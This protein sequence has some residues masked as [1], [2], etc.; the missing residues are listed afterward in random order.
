MNAENTPNPVLKTLK[1][2]TALSVMTIALM[3]G[4]GCAATNSTM[5][6]SSPERWNPAQLDDPSRILMADDL[7]PVDGGSTFA[8]LALRHAETQGDWL[9]AYPHAKAAFEAAPENDSLRR[10]VFLFAVASGDME[11]ASD[12]SDQM[13][14]NDN[15]NELAIT[16]RLVHAVDQGKLSEA[17]EILSEVD[18][19]SGQVAKFILPLLRAWLEFEVSEDKTEALGMIQALVEE[20]R[21]EE[22]G[23]DALF[24]FHAALMN[25]AAGKP[26]VAEEWYKDALAGS[27][28]YRILRSQGA[29]LVRQGRVDEAIDLYDT[30]A[31]RLGPAVELDAERKRIA[32]GIA[33]TGMV[34]SAAKGI[35]ETLFDVGSVLQGRNSSELPLVYGQMTL[36]LQPEHDFAQLLVGNTLIRRDQ[37]KQ[38]I[39]FFEGIADDAPLGWRSRLGLSDALIDGGEDQA[40]LELLTDLVEMHPTRQS[41]VTRL[42]QLKRDMGKDAEAIRLYD[43]LID[44]IEEPDANDWQIWYARAIAHDET[45]NWKKAEADLLK[46]LELKPNQPYVLNYLGYTWADRNERLDEAL[47]MIEKA[48]AQRPNDGYL[49]DSLGWVLYRMGRYDEALPHLEKAAR[50]E[51]SDPA[52]LDH[53]GD[54]YHQQGR[55]R[56]ARFIWV[57]AMGYADDEELRA[58]IRKK[59]DG[60]DPLKVEGMK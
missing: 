22:G 26:D 6:G 38:A 39:P 58:R 44:S 2:S 40:A 47:K 60:A 30:A 34:D 21:T 45:D 3:V 14:G 9:T 54:I 37:P 15:L 50:L 36:A 43:R 35:A 57:R 53:L 29:F 4:A 18:D 52:I 25:E 10:R 20:T 27:F 32:E 31:A 28:A 5:G 56:E 55:L 8:Y 24:A 23:A 19:N 41:A 11:T 46:T 49:V 1:R 48:V 16:A 17:R 51:A 42:A 12:I 33:P 59:L 7:R 13:E